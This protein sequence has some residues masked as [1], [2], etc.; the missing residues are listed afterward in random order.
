MAVLVNFTLLLGMGRANIAEGWFLLPSIVSLPSTNY[1][2]PV[3]ISQKNTRLIPPLNSKGTVVLLC[4]R[5]LGWTSGVKEMC[6]I[7]KDMVLVNLWLLG[8]WVGGLV[9][10]SFVAWRAVCYVRASPLA[11]NLPT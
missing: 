4:Y 8:R 3:N 6:S 9:L 7:N 2:G 11:Y 5:L 1:V 10:Y